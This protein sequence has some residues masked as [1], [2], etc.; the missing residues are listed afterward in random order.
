V[1]LLG[2]LLPFI[3]PLWSQVGTVHI[4]VT[5]PD[6]SGIPGATV[7]QKDAWGRTVT[8][9]AIDGAGEF[10]WMRLPL[11]DWY[12]YAQAPGFYPAAA[13]VAICDRALEHTISLQLAPVPEWDRERIT[14]D[15]EAS[16]IE[17]IPMPICQALDLASP[18]PRPAA[19]HWWQI[20][21]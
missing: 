20:F 3:A 1:A 17:I 6:G 21:R 7:S 9:V 18:Q 2:A 8:T 16:M 15:A 13:G 12:F 11:G 10:L 19:R 5:D 14:V 4:R